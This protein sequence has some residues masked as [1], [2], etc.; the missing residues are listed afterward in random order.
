MP[1]TFLGDLA[2]VRD[3][4]DLLPLVQVRD[5]EILRGYHHLTRCNV[6]R[7]RP[8]PFS[9][10]RV[11]G[12]KMANIFGCGPGPAP[13]SHFILGD[14][15]RGTFLLPPDRQTDSNSVSL[16]SSPACEDKVEVQCI[17]HVRSMWMQG[18]PGYK[19]G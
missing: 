6:V 17:P 14:S 16:D 13:F 3:S 7:S 4:K 18:H 10:L 11:R 5:M 2:T 19:Q 8:G 15:C 9:T 1:S 12:P